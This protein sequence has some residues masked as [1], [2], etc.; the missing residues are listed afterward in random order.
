MPTDEENI[1]YLYLVLTNGGPP[2]VGFTLRPSHPN[3]DSKEPD[4]LRR[5]F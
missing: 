4:R 1:Q 5:G 2:V 3:T